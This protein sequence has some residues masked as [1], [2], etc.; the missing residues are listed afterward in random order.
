[1]RGCFLEFLCFKEKNGTEIDEGGGGKGLGVRG[2]KKHNENTLYEKELSIK[3]TRV[4]KEKRKVLLTNRES[5]Q[6]A[7]LGSP[8]PAHLIYTPAV[9]SSSVPKLS[10]LKKKRAAHSASLL[11]AERLRQDK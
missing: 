7:G 2:G 6:A 1:M 9:S 10:S 3:K 8:G 4:K 11:G 5:A